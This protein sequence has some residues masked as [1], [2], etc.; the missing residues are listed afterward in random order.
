[1]NTLEVL[2]SMQETLKD[3][4][5]RARGY[6]ATRS[7]GEAVSPTAPTA[8]CWCLYG[9]AMKALGTDSFG[10][11]VNHPVED[12]LHRSAWDLF[13]LGPISV[14][15]TR[16]HADLLTLLSHA[17]ATERAANAD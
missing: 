10:D 2:L 11:V 6:C 17:I 1:M 9:A 3:E 12:R 4:T 14:N 15:D 7:D 16:S 13:R 5:R 8:T